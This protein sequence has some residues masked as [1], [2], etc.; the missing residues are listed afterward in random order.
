MMSAEVSKYKQEI[1][2]AIKVL[3]GT[4]GKIKNPEVNIRL[5]K[6]SADNFNSKGRNTDKRGVKKDT[7]RIKILQDKFEESQEKKL[8]EK[9]KDDKLKE[10]HEKKKRALEIEKDMLLSSIRE[11]IQPYVFAMIVVLLSTPNVSRS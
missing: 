7:A 11:K 3:E 1:V 9:K 2:E 10:E 6:P 8:S 5:L 4:D